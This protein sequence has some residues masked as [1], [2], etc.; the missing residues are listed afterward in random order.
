MRIFP[1]EY[2][3]STN[4]A[5]STSTLLASVDMKNP[6][7]N[8]NDPETSVPPEELNDDLF[9]QAWDDHNGASLGATKVKES[10]AA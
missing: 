2:S 4:G 7:A 5:D 10:Q 3:C 6:H 1:A 8:F 9:D